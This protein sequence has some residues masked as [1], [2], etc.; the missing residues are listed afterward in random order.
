MIESVM[1]GPLGRQVRL[2]AG[3]ACIVAV[4]AATSFGLQHIHA[5]PIAQA[6]FGVVFRQFALLI[7][8][9]I[10][11]VLFWRLLDL[12]YVQRSPNRIADLKAEIR[13]FVSDS[14]RMIGGIIASGLMTLVFVSFAQI[15][16]LIPTLNPFS[17]DAYFAQLDQTLH[18][19][20][21]PHELLFPVFGAHSALS[22]F[23]GIYN[24]WLFLMYFVLVIACFLKPD[25]P[26]RIRYLIAFIL[27]WSIGGNLLA[28]V[29]SS[30]GPVFFYDLGLG[31]IYVPLMQELRAH[32]ATGALTVV[33]TQDLLWR[34]YEAGQPLNAISAFP[35]MHVASS[36]LMAIFAFRWHRRAGLALSA[37]ALAMMIASVLLAWHYAVDGYAGALIA[38]A[39]WKVSGWLIRTRI[40]PLSSTA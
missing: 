5:R 40:G 17:W 36:T 19:G 21:L 23:T 9:M 12:T 31:D 38:I 33:A 15:K 20:T 22:F 10:F 27:C 8:Q 2:H 14:D 32:A 30:A 13:S 1:N 25:N 39:S 18:F 4:Y 28:V 34:W 7:P 6:G 35:S 29:F 24:V 16:N 26:N 37:F 11:M 3:L